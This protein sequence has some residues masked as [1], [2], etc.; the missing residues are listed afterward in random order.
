[1]FHHYIAY[2]QIQGE[3]VFMPESILVISVI[4]LI[5]LLYKLCTD[6]M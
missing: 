1:M 5:I 3:E 6:E 2:K 4:A